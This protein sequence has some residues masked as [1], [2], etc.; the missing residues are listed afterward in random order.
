MSD[1]P[2]QIDTFSVEAEQSLIGALLIV[3]DVYDRLCDKVS[4]ADFYADSHRRIWRHIVALL[5]AGRAVDVLTVMDAA[6]HAGDLE[7]IGGLGYL[8]EIANATPS[9]ANAV[10]YAEIIR[11]RAMLRRLLAATGEVSDLAMEPGASIEEKIDFAQAKFLALSDAK[12]KQHEPVRAADVLSAVIGRMEDGGQAKPA[13]PTGFVDLDKRMN[14]GMRGGDFIIVAARPGMGKTAFALNI[15]ENVAIEGGLP[16]AVFSMEMPNEQLASRA[17]GS[18]G[19]VD[20]GR[21]A[22]NEMTDDDWSRLSFAAGKL[23]AAPLYLDE[24]PALR[25][26]DV[27]NKARQVKRMAGGLGL[28][29]VDYLQL[30]VGDGKVAAENRNSEIEKISRGLKAL[31]KEMDIPVIALSQLNRELERRPNKRPQMSDLRDSGAIE[32]DAD[33]IF[34]IYRDEVYNPDSP[35]AGMAEVIIG[36]C[37]AGRAGG[38]VGLAYTGEYT[39]FENAAHGWQPQASS[40]RSGGGKRY[41]GDGD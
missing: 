10:R 12:A 38:H 22:R 32:Q 11:D 7:Q 21:F 20:L 5:S 37:R 28:L 34:F 39:R 41:G 40:S 15:A 13:T 18:I 27:R 8:G 2:H 4:E 1:F 23:Q 6:E 30:M 16:V 19:R 14:G 3:P 25:L 31:A 24:Q 26:L 35:D 17:V 36:K 33:A 29:V 9:A